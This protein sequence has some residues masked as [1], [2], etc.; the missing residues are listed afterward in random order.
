MNLTVPLVH[1]RLPE[2]LL[3]FDYLVDTETAVS[4]LAYPE[5]WAVR[6]CKMWDDIKTELDAAMTNAVSSAVQGACHVQEHTVYTWNS[7]G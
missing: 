3:D 1:L 4:T 5:V 6:A 7:R 2:D